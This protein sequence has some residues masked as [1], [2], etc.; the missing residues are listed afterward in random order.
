MKSKRNYPYVFQL[1]APIYGWFY[2]YQKRSFLRSIAI[3]E[4]AG[5][6]SGVSSILDIGCGTGALSCALSEKGYSVTGIDPVVG[7][8]RIARKKA[9][10]QSINYLV[11]NVLDGLNMEDNLYEIAVASYVAHGLTKPNR[12]IMY[13][14]MKR[15][16]RDKVFFI[17]YNQKRNGFISF[18]EWL[19][20]GDY[21]HYIKEVNEELAEYFDSVEVIPLSKYGALYIC[22]IQEQDV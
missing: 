11:G 6:L 14:E 2:G 12:L 8:I 9:K 22:D 16:A 13:E 19:E 10:Q 15:V 5:I 17:E 20:G 4:E 18:V 1:I 3:M 21:F 7:M